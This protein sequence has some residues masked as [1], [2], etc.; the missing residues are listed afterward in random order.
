MVTHGDM[1]PHGLRLTLDADGY[2]RRRQEALEDLARTLAVQVRES[3]EEAVLEPLNA[4]E[5]RIVHSV[6]TD[7]PDVCTYSEGEGLDRHVVISPRSK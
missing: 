5:R 6:L 7:D 2:R 1:A 4:L 3:G